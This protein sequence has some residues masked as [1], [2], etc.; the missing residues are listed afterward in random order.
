MRLGDGFPDSKGS[1]AP[2][3]SRIIL[4]ASSP[5]FRDRMGHPLTLKKVGPAGN[6]SA[7]KLS[8]LL[9]NLPAQG[10]LRNDCGW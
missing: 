7:A 4:S 1:P 8:I 3:A 6:R 2:R 10:Q 9:T 5:L